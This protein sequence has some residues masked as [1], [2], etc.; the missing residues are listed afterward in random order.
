[1]NWPAPT[2]VA[3]QCSFIRRDREYVITASGG[4][5]IASWQVASKAEVD[6]KV[7]SVREKAAM[8]AP[9]ALWSN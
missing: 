2:T 9:G 5:E 3:T 8:P 6:S 4:V 1:M 7:G